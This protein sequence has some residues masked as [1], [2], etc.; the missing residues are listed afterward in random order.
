[1]TKNEQTKRAVEAFKQLSQTEQAE[2]F[3][4]AIASI[5]RACRI[6]SLMPLLERHL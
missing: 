1:V 6:A 4:R 2:V 3:R 5:S